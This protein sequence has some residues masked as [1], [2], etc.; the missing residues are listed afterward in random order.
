MTISSARPAPSQANG[1][2]QATANSG[3]KI[4]ASSTTSAAIWLT[5]RISGPA[6]GLRVTACN[7][8]PAVA[9]SAPAA[10]STSRRGRRRSSRVMA[11]GS[12][13]HTRCQ[14][15]QT[16][17]SPCAVPATSSAR[18]MNTASTTNDHKGMRMARFSPGML[19]VTAA[20]GALR[21]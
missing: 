21:P 5:P 3:M 14:N 11:R 16:P 2:R 1:K 17:D 6:S 18:Q 13:V 4:S 7:S 19:A 12:L 10:M 15:A 20:T 8:I 9:S